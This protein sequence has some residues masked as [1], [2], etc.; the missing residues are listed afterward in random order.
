M[1]ITQTK[2]PSPVS[3]LKSNVI[4]YLLSRKGQIVT[5]TARRDVKLRAAYKTSV[6]E[7]ISTFQAQVGIE[8]DN[9]TSV[10]AKRVSGEL[11]SENAGLP[12]GRWETYPYVIE[13]NG[14]R[15]F[16]FYTVNN[17]FKVE[18]RYFL[19][20]QEVPKET[21]EPLA[22]ASEFSEKERDCFV[23]PISNII[24]VK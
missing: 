7:K 11:P 14:K 12:W 5:L 3:L 21:L 15:Y 16:R 10:Q 19:D 6:A 24:S 1:N 2:I 17:S 22:L 23:F 8:Y 20:G 9:K 4:P 13:H 18:S